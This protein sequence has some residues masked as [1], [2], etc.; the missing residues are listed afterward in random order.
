MMKKR[1]TLLPFVLI[2]VLAFSAG[3]FIAT[4]AP[5]RAAAANG[6]GPEGDVNEDRL[7]NA[8]K[9]VRDHSVRELD[10][11]ELVRAAVE[12]MLEQLDDRYAEFYDERQSGHVM[13]PFSPEF[14]GIGVF[15][16]VHERGV[17]IVRV[18]RDTPAEEAG[19]KAGDLI[20]AVDGEEIG[21]KELDY[22]S[23]LIKGPIDTTV[24]LRVEDELGRHS[25]VRVRRGRISVPSVDFQPVH[26]NGKVYGYLVIEKFIETTGEEVKWALDSLGAVHGLILDVRDNPGGL[27]GQAI[28][29]CDLLVPPGPIVSLERR[30]GES[31]G[32]DSDSPGLDCPV[33]VLVNHRTASASEIVAGALRDRLGA[34]LVGTT[35]YGKSTVQSV[36]NFDGIGLKLTSARYLTPSGILLDGSG[37]RPDIDIS[38]SGQEMGCAAD[39]TFPLGPSD[40]GRSVLSLETVLV[41]M[42]YLRAEPD[43]EYDFRTQAAVMRFQADH[44]IQPSGVFDAVTAER[45]NSLARG[46]GAWG[47]GLLEAESVLDIFAPAAHD[48]Q[49]R[50]A[51]EVLVFQTET[52]DA[53]N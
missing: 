14:S 26:L 46:E 16:R 23:H 5:M 50:R 25:T 28:H 37:L 41:Q 35:T 6:P 2:A 27:L 42:G 36:F 45:M 39:L 52:P 44:G 15:I 17:V 32:F 53:G 10:P 40:Q 13:D 1:S 48:A 33:V 8:Y 24:T 21:G 12:G 30:G 11:E 3:L 29:V 9:I 47:R 34:L 31:E 22:I 4:D 49:L 7:I 19:L 18:I 20:T 43:E 38:G 51:L